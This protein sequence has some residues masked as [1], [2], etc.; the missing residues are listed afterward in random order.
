MYKRNI[1]LL[2][3][4][5]FFH[6]LIPAYIIERLYWQE[7]GMVVGLVVWTEIIYALTVVILEVPSGL[8]ADRWGRR[9]MIIIS[10]L[11]GFLE[12]F[13]LLYATHFTHFALAIFLAGVGKASGSGA[14]NALLYDSLAQQGL[15]NEFEKVLGRQIAIDF[16]AALLA[17]LSGS[18]AAAYWGMTSNY[19]LSILS[20][21]IALGFAFFLKEPPLK[22]EAE[23]QSQSFK[24]IA[25]KALTFFRSHKSVGFIICQAMFIAACVVYVDEFWQIYFGDINFPLVWFGV[26]GALFVLA[27][28]PGGLLASRLLSKISSA[29]L[30]FWLTATTALAVWQIA[31]SQSLWGV[32]GFTVLFFCSGMLEPISLG[33]MHRQADAE[34]RATIDSLASLIERIFVTFIGLSFGYLADYFN[35]FYGFTLLACLLT[36]ACCFIPL[37]QKRLEKS[38]STNS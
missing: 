36:L 19:Q 23:E 7:R 14:W 12:L 33:F 35:I 6:N 21:S 26:I 17:A 24:Q 13:I 18:L 31:L 8:L 30:M 2:Y 11:L 25:S 1:H 20:A 37:A 10:S 5:I 16:S 9:P 22:S 29:K 15:E 3:V 34:A 28:I 27:R 32:L 4:I 38:S